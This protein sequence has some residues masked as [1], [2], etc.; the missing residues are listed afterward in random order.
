MTNLAIFAS[1]SGTNAEK[2]ISHFKKNSGVCIKLIVCNNPKAFVTQRAKNHGID[3][4][5]ISKQEL[6]HDTDISTTFHEHQIHWIVL[7]GFLL[8]VPTYLID[9]FPNKIINLHPALLPK[10]GGKG[11]YGMHV[12]NAVIENGESKSGITI[13]FVNQHYDEGKIIAQFSCD[14]VS[15]DTPETLAQKI[16]QLEHRHYP[17]A[18]EKLISNNR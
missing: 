6:Q 15:S 14:V 18:I 13:H 9:L 1:G 7:A 3:C 8:L 12:H 5:I 17:L 2:I 11:M 4:M 10:Y 16:H